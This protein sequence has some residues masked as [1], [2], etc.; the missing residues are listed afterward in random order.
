MKLKIFC[1]QRGDK[2]IQEIFKETPSENQA[3]QESNK[4]LFTQSLSKYLT[5]IPNTNFT[6]SG[7]VALHSNSLKSL[8]SV[9]DHARVCHKLHVTKLKGRSHVTVRTL[10]RYLSHSHIC[11]IT[12]NTKKGRLRLCHKTLIFLTLLFDLTGCFSVKHA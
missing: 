12:H 11:E 9:K 2:F 4:T 7:T 5:F 8:T 3:F 6:F 1:R 10:F